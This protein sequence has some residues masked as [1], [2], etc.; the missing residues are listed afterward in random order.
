MCAPFR[1]RSWNGAASYASHLPLRTLRI[2]WPHP[3][4]PP[5]FGPA[6]GCGHMASYPRQV[7]AGLAN[8]WRIPMV[9]PLGI[10]SRMH[11]LPGQGDVKRSACC[12]R[13]IRHHAC[14]NA[15]RVALHRRLHLCIYTAMPICSRGMGSTSQRGQW[16]HS[17]AAC[18]CL[19]TGTGCQLAPARAPTTALLYCMH[20]A[21]RVRSRALGPPLWVGRTAVPSLRAGAWGQA[22][23][24]SGAVWPA[25]V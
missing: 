12:M 18:W 16:R 24:C 9:C 3:M 2:C 10:R 5:Y 14:S 7:L 11:A 4:L 15:L 21:T 20:T 1:Q 25:A 19:G 6:A 8:G 23:A 17:L 13:H 22:P